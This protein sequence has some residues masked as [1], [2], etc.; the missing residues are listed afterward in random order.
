[1]SCSQLAM[2]ALQ[3]HRRN[4]AAVLDR[5]SVADDEGLLDVS[6]RLHVHGWMKWLRSL[7]LT[8]HCA[9]LLPESV[10]ID[11]NWNAGDV[12]CEQSTFS[13]CRKR[14]LTNTVPAEK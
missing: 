10:I 3:L 9:S 12:S 13:Y 6:I 5:S 11:W 4:L 8:L 14:Y 7:S 2:H 1:M